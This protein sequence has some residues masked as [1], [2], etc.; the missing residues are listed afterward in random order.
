MTNVLNPDPRDEAESGT[1]L[2]KLRI[3]RLNGQT[4]DL[5]W[6]WPADLQ[7]V[8]LAQ[9]FEALALAQEVDPHTLLELGRCILWAAQSAEG[10]P[11][12]SHACQLLRCSHNGQTLSA[13]HRLHLQDDDQIEVGLCR[14]SVSTPHL[15]Q[16]AS[17]ASAT[18]APSEVG[19]DWGA[20][21][22]TSP[23][24]IADLLGAS[25][26]ESQMT[27][28]LAMADANDPLARW[29]QHYLR[30][31][32]FPHEQ[33]QDGAWSAGTSA[34][35]AS[36]GKAH[37]WQDPFDTLIKEQQRANLSEMLGQGE[38][39]GAVLLTL[40]AQSDQDILS[41]PTPDNVLH[42]FAPEHWQA[43]NENQT[44]PLLSRIEHHGVALNSAI[45]SDDMQTAPMAA[46]SPPDSP[47]LTDKP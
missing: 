37:A 20:L 13:N 12:F 26:L 21:A 27:E 31:L 16:A 44:L 29:H 7:Q 45:R 8:S 40:D 32:R 3:L 15:H 19:P 36:S 33:V 47:H 22:G 41:S 9:V 6:A 28:A 24:G 34:A 25:V 18:A 30:H 39:I 35:A 46:N 4:L 11:S 42:L 1:N 38:N 23:Q 5:D 2:S 14:F 43:P 17:A 10:P